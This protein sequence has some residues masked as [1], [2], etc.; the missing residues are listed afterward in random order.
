MFRKISSGFTGGA[1]GAFIDSF[2]IWLLGK[3]GVTSLLGVSMQPHFTTKWLYPRLVWGGLWGLLFL[4]PFSKRHII[5]KGLIISLAPSAI[6]LF[7]VFP[8]MG[9]GTFGTG[10]GTL[11]PV[12]VVLL[13]FIWGI[14]AGLWYKQ[15]TS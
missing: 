5:N 11:T 1:I 15:A 13:N 10:F 6:M 4:L 12:L 2:N 9:K 3:A 14:T 7:I 8:N